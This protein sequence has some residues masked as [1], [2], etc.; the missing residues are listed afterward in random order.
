MHRAAIVS[1]TIAPVALVGGWSWAATRQRP[2]YDAVRDTI[3]SL[4]ARGAHDRWIMTTALIVLG[5]CH[6][7]TAAGL[8]EARPLGRISLGL[9]G[10]ATIGVAQL[11]QPS[12]GH[13]PMATVAFVALSAWPAL[14]GV[15][16]RRAATLATASL[17]ML[18][19]WLVVALQR[20]SL[21]GIAERALAA[22]QA[23]WPLCVVVM[24]SIRRST[25][26]ARP[27]APDRAE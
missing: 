5:L 22:G 9:G 8:T 12:A 11:P 15:P 14:A 13:V 27:V 6:T 17:T 16:T 19:G 10:I 1:A 25:S 24:V 23:L 7:V 4:A 21:I 26:T 2:G 20:G 3:S 18:L